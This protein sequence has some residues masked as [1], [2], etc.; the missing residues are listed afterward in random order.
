MY[1]L[2]RVVQCWDR[3]SELV[4][5]CL[6]EL[7]FPGGSDGKQSA[8]N[9]GD[10]GLISGS[11]RSLG[12]GNGYPGDSGG[13]ESACNAGDTGLISGSGRSLGERNGNLLQYAC[14][15]IPWTEESGGLQSMGSQRIRHD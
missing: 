9:V 12:E 8:C 10:P 3:M 2:F 13:K 5:I 11:G 6:N 1:Y 7:A 14:W 15:E 4:Y